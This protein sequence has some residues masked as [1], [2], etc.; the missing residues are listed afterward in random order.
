MF[1]PYRKINLDLKLEIL[2]KYWGKS[3]KVATL[4]RQYKVSRDSIYSWAR[5]AEQALI[6]FFQAKRPGPA[7]DELK[8]LRL[9]NQLLKQKPSDLSDEYERLSQY[10]QLRPAKSRTAG[11]IRPNT[12]PHCGHDKVWR[13]G[14]YQ[15]SR[16]PVQRFIC[17]SCR[18]AVYLV[19]K[20]PQE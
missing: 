4:A 3:T 17:A 18:E 7:L 5:E 12:C 19:K 1:M 11:E 20:T 13:N 14:Y 8:K 15:T 10:S 9:E 2:K 6:N 16:G